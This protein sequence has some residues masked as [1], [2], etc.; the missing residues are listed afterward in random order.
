MDISS[1]NPSTEVLFSVDFSETSEI[2]I[3]FL[4]NN[5]LS[6]CIVQHKRAC[7]CPSYGT[8]KGSRTIDVC[9]ESVQF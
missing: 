3:I 5:T 6:L 8:E 4:Y 2:L 9:S 7:S 1:T